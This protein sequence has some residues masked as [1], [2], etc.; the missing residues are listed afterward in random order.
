MTANTNPY[1]DPLDRAV[2]DAS[3]AETVSREPSYLVGL[4]EAQREA[5][6]ATDGPVLVLAGAGTGKTRV[7]T[8]RLAHILATRRAWPGQILCVTFTNKAAREMKERIGA[9]IG[10]VVEGMQWLGTFHSIAAKILRRHAELAG[11]KSNFTILDTDDQL[12]LM[13]Q[14]IDAEGIDEKRWPARTLAA[15]IDAWKNRGLRPDDVSEG[16]AQGY[17]FGKGKQLYRQYQERLKALNAA[18]FGDLLLE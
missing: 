16:E 8:T 12:R 17:A 1:S 7:L 9:L 18:D 3:A 11:L 10:G 14:L 15:M 6:L 4:N 2:E 5:V 13:K